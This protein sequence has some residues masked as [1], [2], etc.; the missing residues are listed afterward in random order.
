MEGVAVQHFKIEVTN[1]YLAQGTVNDISSVF[2]SHIS[3]D[4]KQDAH[5][6]A[7]HIKMLLKE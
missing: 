7:E 1:M 3:D 2:F 6:T 5:T 4:S